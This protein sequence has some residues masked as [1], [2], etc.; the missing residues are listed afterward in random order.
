MGPETMNAP[1]PRMPAEAGGFDKTTAPYKLC[2]FFDFNVEPGKQY[3]YRVRLALKNPNFDSSPATLKSPEL[4]KTTYLETKWS[5]PTAAILVPYDTR[6]LLVS[7]K[8]APRGNN[9]P[10]GQILVSRWVLSKGEQIFKEFKVT[11][12]QTANFPADTAQVVGGNRKVRASF[13]SGAT[14]VDFRGG[15]N[16]SGARGS[17]LTALGEMLLLNHDGT[18]VVHSEL[19]DAPARDRLTIS[20]GEQPTGNMMGMPPE[21]MPGGLEVL[22]RAPGGRRGR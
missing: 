5:E 4:A 15:K 19:D 12:G 10:T 13:A 7:V 2:R 18:L 22:D 11:R 9:D 20:T 8:P 14:A 17:T 3:V 1:P 21:M 6:I 16:L